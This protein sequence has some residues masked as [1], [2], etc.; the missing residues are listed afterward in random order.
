MERWEGG[1]VIGCVYGRRLERVQGRR[2]TREIS[3]I[4]T[5]SHLFFVIC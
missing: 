1:A 3:G 2:T 5:H 4:V